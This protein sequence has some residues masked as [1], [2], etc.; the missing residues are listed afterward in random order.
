M[1]RYARIPERVIT[2][3]HSLASYGIIGDT[4]VRRKDWLV[5]AYYLTL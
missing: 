5:K 4:P 1:L 2:H 3:I